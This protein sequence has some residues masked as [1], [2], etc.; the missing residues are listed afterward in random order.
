MSC[1]ESM[2]FAQLA[3]MRSTTRPLPRALLYFVDNVEKDPDA[4]DLT[5]VKTTLVSIT[6]PSRRGNTERSIAFDMSPVKSVLSDVVEE[7][8]S[9]RDII[10][11]DEGH[12]FER[13]FHY[14]GWFKGQVTQVISDDLRRVHFDEGKKKIAIVTTVELARLESEPKIGEVGFKFVKIFRGG[15]VFNG[16][17]EK[18]MKNGKFFCRFEDNDTLSV[19]KKSLMQLKSRNYPKLR[20]IE[21][22]DHCDP[23]KKNLSASDDGDIESSDEDVPLNR[24]RQRK[25]T[26]NDTEGDRSEGDTDDD[27]EERSYV[28]PDSSE[29]E[30]EDDSDGSF[31]PVAKNRKKREVKTRVSG[32]MGRKPAS[33]RG[34]NNSQ[35]VVSTPATSWTYGK[36]LMTLTLEELEDMNSADVLYRK[37]LEKSMN[38]ISE[39]MSSMKLG[40]R[41]VIMTKY[42][43]DEE[44]QILHDVLKKY[45]PAYDESIRSKKNQSKLGKID[46]FLRCPKH[47]K[48][49]SWGM[50]YKLCGE[51]GCELCPRMPRVLNIGDD[52][53]TKAVLQFCPLP[54]VDADAEEFLTIE[55]CERLLENGA[56]L[57]TELEDLR[58]IRKEAEKADMKTE[59]NKAKKVGMM[60][61]ERISIGQRF[62][63]F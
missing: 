13:F 2:T 32:S 53:L 40:E 6:T 50:E 28:P 11:Y 23:R 26:P 44:V 27:S 39:R 63:A 24:L 20:K 60:W 54:R 18:I 3:T 7:G 29:S 15:G 47:S 17:V 42:P 52:E 51:E 1:P 36:W 35:T 16:M 5:P 33:K 43:T 55:E 41:H 49:T 37:T 46:R 45:E 34:P 9:G 61:S 62:V 12:K 57:A 4:L 56:D 10:A 58:R 31:G 8:D 30:E 38:I 25:S 21:E 14:G 22:L 59:E 19:S 48:I